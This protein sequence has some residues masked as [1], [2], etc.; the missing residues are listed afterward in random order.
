MADTCA[1]F[2]AEFNRLNVKLPLKLSPYEMGD[3]IDSEGRHVC[4]CD[5]NCERPNEDAVA[6]ALYRQSGQ[7]LHRLQ[8]KN[9]P[10]DLEVLL[11]NQD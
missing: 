3:I 1:D 10:N 11:Q 4:I 6:I 7:C 9:R 8:H 5:P 2:V